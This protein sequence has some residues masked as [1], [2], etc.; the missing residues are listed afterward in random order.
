MTSGDKELISFENIKII[1]VDVTDIISP[2]YLKEFIKTSI[3]IEKVRLEPSSKVFISFIQEINRYEIYIVNSSQKYPLILPQVFTTYYSENDISFESIDLFITKDFFVVYKNKK[4]YLSKKNE[5]YRQDDI[6]NYINFNYNLKVD[7]IYVISEKELEKL[8]EKFLKEYICDFDLQY[9][10]L[11]NNSSYRYFLIYLIISILVSFYIFYPKL[12]I[13]PK[14]IV[15]SN[16][17][18]LQNLKLQ[19]KKLS[20]DNIKEEKISKRIIEFFNYLKI[21]KINIIKI[22]YKKSLYAQIIANKKQNLYDFLAIY[23]KKIKIIKLT[24]TNNRFSME[25]QIEF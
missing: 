7:K 23:D 13:E 12:K 5:Q 11:K 16:I 10:T 1:S 8:K 22:E 2:K 14:Q 18:Q 4:L 24:K 19:Y 6:L 3:D 17:E 9:I 21:Y 25:I 20:R 15:T